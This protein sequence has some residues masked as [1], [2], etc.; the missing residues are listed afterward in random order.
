M[1]VRIRRLL[2]AATT[3][4]SGCAPPPAAILPQYLSTRDYANF[5]CRELEIEQGRLDTDLFITA[6]AQ[7]ETRFEDT[8]SVIN[9]LLPIASL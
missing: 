3:C 6:S 4:L 8:I 9:F 1:A 7:G 5:S 2:V